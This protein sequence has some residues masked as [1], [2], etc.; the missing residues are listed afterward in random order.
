MDQRF[1][2]MQAWLLGLKRFQQGELTHPEPASADA[3]FR[4][5]FRVRFQNDQQA[6]SWIIMDAPP[7]QEDSRPFIRVADELAKL[8]LN[9][10]E[11][12]EQNLEQGFLLLSD[13]GATTYLSVLNDDN[14]DKLYADALTPLITLQTQAESSHLPDYDSA[15]LI[16]EM[17]LFSEWLAQ[18]HCDLRMNS[19]EHQAWLLVQEHLTRAAL[20]QPQVYVHRDY[21]SR[22]LMLTE[23]NNPGILDFQD[24]VQGP[25]T[26]DAVSLLR[27]C[28]IVWP[29]ERVR[30]WQRQYFLNLCQA[31]RLTKSEWPN[32]VEAFDLMGV[33][34]HLKASG[35][36]ARLLHRD[37]KPGYIKD[38][39]A[40]LDYII[41]IGRQYKELSSLV[42]WTEKLALR[43][44]EN[45][46]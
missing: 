35:I 34:R 15:L 24:A 3:S 32:F 9:V 42:A 40:T 14:V 8:G 20:A 1:E 44:T 22:N 38:I 18:A 30:D 43:F 23:A 5:Y 28:Y 26:Y 21:H 4:R 29:A 12:A 37:G 46:Q 19:T 6:Q 36:F 33:Q 16:T 41:Q 31:G 7:Q 45:H 13:L 10:P 17:D 39:P 2:E 11:V 27:D 25:L